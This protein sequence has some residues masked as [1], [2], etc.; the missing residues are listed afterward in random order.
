MSKN[1]RKRSAPAPR[2]LE[3]LNGFVVPNADAQRA[4]LGDDSNPTHRHSFPE[5]SALLSADLFAP[6]PA[7]PSDDRGAPR[8]NTTWILMSNIKFFCLPSTDWLVNNEERQSFADYCVLACERR[9]GALKRKMRATKRT[10]CLLPIGAF[11]SACMPNVLDTI[12]TFVSAFFA[13]RVR[14]LPR[15]TV[16]VDS[17]AR[18]TKHVLWSDSALLAA[19]AVCEFDC[20]LHLRSATSATSAAESAVAPV[21]AAPAMIVARTHARS[22]GRQLHT[23]A[24]LSELAA[25]FESTDFQPALGAD[26]AFVVGVTMEDLFS[27]AFLPHCAASPSKPALNVFQFRRKR[28]VCCGYGSRRLA[29]WCVFAISLSTR[30]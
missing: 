26:A 12:A 24:I 19:H 23:D 13:C 6:I 28:P 7:H 3:Y 4:A 20:G 5:C 17:H 21:A 15:V 22:G 1:A 25:Q 2:A 9:T 10:I 18:A 8:A 14:V 30:L 16:A 11:E 29:R 27:R